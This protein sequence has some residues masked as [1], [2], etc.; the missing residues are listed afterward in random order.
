MSFD[1]RLHKLIRELGAD[2]VGVAFVAQPPNPLPVRANGLRLSV[3]HRGETGRRFQPVLPC[4]SIF[5]RP[6]AW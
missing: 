5:D 6:I 1:Q 2:F 4:G 3:E